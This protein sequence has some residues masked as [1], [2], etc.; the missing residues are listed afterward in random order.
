M[1]CRRLGSLL[2]D[3][4]MAQLRDPP[5]AVTLAEHAVQP[6]AR[7]ADWLGTVGNSSIPGWDPTAAIGALKKAAELL[8]GGNVQ[9]WLFLAMACCQA[10]ERGQARLWYDKAIARIETYPPGDCNDRPFARRSGG[11]PGQRARQ[12]V[13]FAGPL[14]YASLS[15]S[16]R[17]LLWLPGRPIWFGHGAGPGRLV[18][19]TERRRKPL[20]VV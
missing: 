18:G 14:L 6:C 7:M 4:P 12:V 19:T 11:A 1:S 13:T 5:R 20:V 9:Q 16:F 15:P 10:G 3:C 17:L 2:A 8:E